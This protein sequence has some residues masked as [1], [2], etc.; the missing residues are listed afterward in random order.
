MGWKNRLWNTICKRD[1]K[2]KSSNLS[3]IFIIFMWNV[4]ASCIL[5]WIF[6][7]KKYKGKK[8]EVR[9]KKYVYAAGRSLAAQP[10]PRPRWRVRWRQPAEAGSAAA[11]PSSPAANAVIWDAQMDAS[12]ARGGRVDIGGRAAAFFV[13][14]APSATRGRGG[15]QRARRRR[16]RHE[17]GVPAGHL[18]R[19][20]G[21]D[22][23]ASRGGADLS[24][25]ARRGGTPRRRRQRSSGSRVREKGEGISAGAFAKK[26]SY[27]WVISST[28]LVA[29]KCGLRVRFTVSRGLFLQKRQGRVHWPS[30]RRRTARIAAL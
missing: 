1:R 2:C 5:I 25:E 29:M 6:C 12:D 16:F 7:L 21:G 4:L 23:G 27:F 19:G 3:N 18:R 15:G 9:E 22:D 24:A 17:R 11:A 28:S 30:D 14:G 8:Q 13:A 26:T 20:G 10:S